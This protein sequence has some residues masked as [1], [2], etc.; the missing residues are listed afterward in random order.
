MGNSIRSLGQRWGVAFLLVL[1]LVSVWMGYTSSI[2][3]QLFVDTNK[4]TE[5]ER[6]L[7]TGESCMDVPTFS[8]GTG[9]FIALWVFCQEIDRDGGIA[10]E[11]LRV[12]NVGLHLLNGLLVFFFCWNLFR[13]KGQAASAMLAAAVALAWCLLPI[14]VSS[15][16]YIIQRMTLFATLFS[17]AS[18]LLLMRSIESTG[19][20]AKSGYMVGGVLCLVAAFYSKETALVIFPYCVLLYFFCYQDQ[21]RNSAWY[22]PLVTLV[23]LLAFGAVSWA[24][25]LLDYTNVPFSLHE[26]LVSFPRVLSFYT[27]EVL[28]PMSDDVGLIQD[29]FKIS[30]GIFA[31]SYNL[32]VCAFVLGI[33]VWAFWVR[34]LIGFGWLFFVFGHLL[35]G[36]VLPLEL[37]YLHRNYLPSLGLVIAVVL[38]LHRFQKLFLLMPLILLYAFLTVSRVSN[39]STQESFYYSAVKHHPTSVRAVSGVSQLLTEK[40]R[41]SAAAEALENAVESNPQQAA[42]LQLQQIFVTCLSGRAIGQDL[43]ARLGENGPSYPAK[44]FNQALLNVLAVIEAG[45]CGDLKN[46]NFYASLRAMLQIQLEAGLLRDAERSYFMSTFMFYTGREAEAKQYL[47]MRLEEGEFNSG[48]YL[49]ELVVKTNDRGMQNLVEEKLRSMPEFDPVDHSFSKIIPG[50]SK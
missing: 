46:Q 10:P 39:W 9:R 6:H 13:L 11:K 32:L 27:L 24:F 33:T 5:L 17:L 19:N 42:K 41:Y 21:K 1:M 30:S 28:V 25:G 18:L 16:V 14:H 37:V 43:I 45:G 12:M 8:S 47:M 44:E 23:G 2:S 22:L 26:R 31:P 4:L 35:E 3:Q 48:L 7:G 34:S 36:S 29:D 15:V 38:L 20:L 50:Y 40:G 49:L